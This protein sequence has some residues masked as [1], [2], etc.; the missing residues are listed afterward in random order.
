MRRSNDDEFFVWLAVLVLGAI[1][2]WV[3]FKV[4]ALSSW[5]NV[6]MKTA[7]SVMLRAVV[8]LAALG[9]ALLKGWIGKVLPYVPAAAVMVMVPALSF[10][11]WAYVQ[12][13]VP[14]AM[15][16]EQAWYGVTWIQVVCVASLA[17]AGFAVQHW[18]DENY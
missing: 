8:L 9:F 11:S 15:N 16:A 14:V 6:D 10:W 13:D 18:I 17:A 5:M 7:F 4:Q 2:I 1:S 3:Y 12:P